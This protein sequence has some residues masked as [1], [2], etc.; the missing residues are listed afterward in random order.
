M[1]KKR[2]SNANK[3]VYAMVRGKEVVIENKNTVYIVNNT[4]LSADV[5]AEHHRYIF[6]YLISE[7]FCNNGRIKINVLFNH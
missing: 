1:K 7:G 5:F 3:A 2:T 4:A 6:E